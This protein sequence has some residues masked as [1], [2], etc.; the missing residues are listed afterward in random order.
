MNTST[1]KIMLSAIQ[2]SNRLTIGNYLGA[3]KQWVTLQQNFDCI[4]IAVDMH[5]ITVRQN[6]EELR[7]QTYRAI[8]TYIASGINPEDATL[9]V[10]SHVPQHAELSWALTCHSYMGEL[11]RMTQ[12]KD[13]TSRQ[14]E[15]ISAGLFCYPIL[16]AADVLLYQADLVPVGQDQKQH[17]ELSRDLAIR[18]RNLYGEDLFKVPGIYIPPVGAKIMSL[19]DPTLKMSKSDPDPNSAIYLNDTDEQIQKKLRRAVT[20]SGSEITFED[21]KPGIKNLLTIQAALTGKSTD[22]IVASYAGKQYGHLKVE[23]AEIV[24]SALKP[25][26]EKTNEL[27]RDIAYLN[28]V[29]KNGAERASER[30]QKTLALVYDRLGFIPRP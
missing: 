30:A 11:G 23:T 18:M 9:F 6:P 21:I 26:R 28:S 15:N 13:K 10:Q 27:L 8:A 5:A 19:Q 7:R 14:G 12:F 2:P 29:L 4:F 24:I 25:I 16:M 17:L 22:A 3:L 20:D 1:K